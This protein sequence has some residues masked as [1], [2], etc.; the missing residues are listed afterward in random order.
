MRGSRRCRFA[1]TFG[2]DF[3]SRND[4]GHTEGTRSPKLTHTPLDARKLANRIDV[5][6]ITAVDTYC[7]RATFNERLDTW[8]VSNTR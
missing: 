1:G 6:T 3:E 8:N 4:D 5:A 2:S 7:N